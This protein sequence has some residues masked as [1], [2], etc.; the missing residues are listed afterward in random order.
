MNRSLQELN[1]GSIGFGNQGL[2]LI[3]KLLLNKVPLTSLLLENNKISSRG[4]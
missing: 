1:L 4:F 2:A 3:S